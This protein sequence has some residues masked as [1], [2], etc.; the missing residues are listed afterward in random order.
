MGY[1]L[2]LQFMEK[3]KM[4][5][6][7]SLSIKIPKDQTSG[8]FQLENG[9]KLVWQIIPTGQECEESFEAER[10]KKLDAFIENLGGPLL[11]DDFKPLSKEEVH[12]R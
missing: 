12:E 8:E 7:M 11:P 2:Y 1:V 9:K 6:Q 4:T 10:C 5:T 3:V